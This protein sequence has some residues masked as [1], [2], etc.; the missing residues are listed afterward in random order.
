MVSGFMDYK[1][2]YIPRNLVG[3]D[4]VRINKIIFVTKMGCLERW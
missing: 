3:T 2:R 4:V 1:H